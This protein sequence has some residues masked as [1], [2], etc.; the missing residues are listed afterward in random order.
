MQRLFSALWGRD[1]QKN[2]QVN[3]DIKTLC[4]LLKEQFDLYAHSIKPYIQLKDIEETGGIIMY[5]GNGNLSVEKFEEKFHQFKE[6][7]HKILPNIT[8]DVQ[9]GGK[10]IQATFILGIDEISLLNQQMEHHFKPHMMV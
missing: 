9:S 8:F 10:S 6:T 4:R 2:T 7:V 3:T 5:V 1:S